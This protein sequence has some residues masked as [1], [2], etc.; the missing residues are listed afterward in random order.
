V[1]DRSN[2]GRLNK[3]KTGQNI[4]FFFTNN[5]SGISASDANA[6]TTQS[7]AQFNQHISNSVNVVVSNDGDVNGRSDI[8]FSSTDP[9]LTDSGVVAVTTTQY[10]PETGRIIEAD[11]IL[12]DTYSFSNSVFDKNYLGNAMTHEIGHALGLS[13][14]QL[15]DATMFFETRKGQYSLHTDDI[16]GVRYLYGSSSTGSIS[17]RVAGSGKLTSVFG[18]HV[19]A[20]SLNTGKAVASSVSE[21]DGTFSI[22]NLPIDD[23][24]FIYVEPLNNLG[25]LPSY[26][27]VAKKD[28]CDSSNSYKGGFFQRCFGDDRGKPYGITL[29]SSNTSVNIGNVSIKCGLEVSRDYTLSKGDVFTPNLVSQSVSSTYVGSS[30]VGFFNSKTIGTTINF[31]EIYD[32]YNLDLSFYDIQSEFPGKNLFLEVKIMTQQFYSPLRVTTIL[33]HEDYASPSY[34]PL[35][36]S[37]LPSNSDGNYDLDITLKLPIHSNQLKNIYNLKILPNNIDK[38][39]TMNSS[40]ILSYDI[41]S[42]ARNLYE[43]NRHF[44]FIT[45]RLVEK[46]GIDYFQVSQKNFGAL[47][48]NTT[49]MDGPQTYSVEA[50]TVYVPAG[51]RTSRAKKNDSDL[52]IACGSIKDIN[53]GPPGNGPLASLFILTL[54]LFLALKI[55][56]SQ[57]IE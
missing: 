36:A 33:D 25:S 20:I 11:I 43:E 2:T 12:N 49:C 26:Y 9:L 52:P 47:S 8:Y 46:V 53:S 3:W 18:A 37:T 45:T 51:L 24:Y 22:S 17:G 39:H 29:S 32:E 21:T 23:T 14:S 10:D 41:Y 16:S 54:S 5:V 19:Y 4:N 15:I 6:I 1:I 48:D 57:F 50:N 40:S 38:V 7:A 30:H 42:L 28:Y 44:Y 34:S 27:N 55:R 31:D 56:S 35:T 13:H